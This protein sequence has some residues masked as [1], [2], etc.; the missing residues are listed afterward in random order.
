VLF[1]L[2][3]VLIDSFDVWWAVVNTT[4]RRFGAPEITREGLLAIFGQGISDDMRN[5]YPGRTRQ[6][7]LAA[8]DEAM[9]ACSTNVRVNPEAVAALTLLKTHGV[10]RAVVTNSQAS[11]AAAVLKATGLDAHLDTW[12]GVSAG[13][14][15]KPAPDLLLHALGRLG[16]E[17]RDALMVGDTDYDER[18]AR[19][20]GTRFLRYEIRKGASLTQALTGAAGLSRA[21]A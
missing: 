17:P 5:L 7:I 13:L 10:Q 11:I 9:P 21:P 14:R 2:D 3:G 15:E 19:T 6:E 16:I 1:D 18:A 12:T 20:A 4:A 8:Y